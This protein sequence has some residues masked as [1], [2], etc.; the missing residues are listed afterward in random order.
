MMACQQHDKVVT[1]ID[2]APNTNRI[3][4]CGQDR[5]AYVWTFTNGVWK[6]V[7]VI[8]RINRAATHV[9]WSPL[10]TCAHL[11]LLGGRAWYSLSPKLGAGSHM[12]VVVV[13]RDNRGQVCRRQRLQ[14]RVGV[15]L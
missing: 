6:P 3:V 14:V 12:V 9:K 13:A 11:G 15:L 8:L 1:G 2:W 5:N 10:G 7:L 4:T